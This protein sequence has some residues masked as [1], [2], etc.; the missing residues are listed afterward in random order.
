M[1][2]LLGPPEGTVIGANL[3]VSGNF[4]GMFAAL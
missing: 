4:G 2:C 3:R 1:A